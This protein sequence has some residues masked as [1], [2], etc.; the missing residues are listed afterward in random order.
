MR[1]ILGRALVGL[2]LLVASAGGAGAQPLGEFSW[3]LSPFCNVV[4][5]NVT[6]DGATYTLDGYDDQCGAPRRG[7]VIGMAFT[8]PDGSIGLGLTI[9]A[10]PG[11]APVHVDGTISLTTLGGPWTDSAGNAGTLVFGAVPIGGSPRPIAAPT[12][13]SAAIVDG[14]IA[15]VDVDVSQ[16]QQRI[17]AACPS[18]QLMTAVN[19][20]GSVACEA[21]TAS[22]GG[23]ITAVNAGLGLTGGGTSG[24]VTLAVNPAAVQA[25][26]SGSCPSGQS[27][28]QI[29][30]DG[31]VTCEADDVGA[32][33]ITDVN[34]GTGLTGGGSAGPVTL[35]VDFGTG[36]GTSPNPARADH[37]HEGAAVGSH[38]TTV[39]KLALPSA[40]PGQD[41]V[42]VGYHALS[43][44][45]GANANV[46]VGSAALEHISSGADNVGVG[47]SAL[48]AE[49]TGS[50]NVAIGPYALQNLDGGS[51]NVAAGNLAGALLT[52]GSDNVYIAS[53]GGSGTENTTIRIGRSI[54]H[55]RAFISGIRGVTTGASNAVAVVI[56]SAGQLGTVSSSRRFKDDIHDLGAVGERLQQLRPVQFRYKKPFA[57]GTKPVQYGLIAEEV[58]EVLPELVA[59]DADGQPST[60]MYHVLPALLVEEVQRLE[61]E[62]TALTQEVQA[63]RALVEGLTAV[64]R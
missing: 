45:S 20:D 19:Q 23:D 28:R 13:D 57:D 51:R 55:T 1:I 40:T 37:T 29:A 15:A 18:G 32:G 21:V 2:G 48:T 30:N 24:S 10:T 8:N 17:S 61:R 62:R 12:V 27:I 38:N 26:V 36:T 7:A 16:I 22:S 6:A 44:A 14:S 41:N 53:S 59:Y 43:S 11:G 3:I 63:L 33:D 31:S 39:G 34:A 42:A 56:D 64:R 4:T 9:V 52:S 25:R 47:L 60:V 54:T 49:K 58:A 5:V 46:A 50:A 35:S